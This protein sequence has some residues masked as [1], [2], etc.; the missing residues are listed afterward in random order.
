LSTTKDEVMQALLEAML[1]QAETPSSL[2]G[3][4]AGAAKTFAE[5]YALLHGC[6]DD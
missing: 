5:A 6:K 4:N 3:S 2:G 1:R